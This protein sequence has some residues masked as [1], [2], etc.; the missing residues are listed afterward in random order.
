MKS[1]G[2]EFFEI[3]GCAPGDE[4]Y[5]DEDAEKQDLI[6]AIPLFTRS[7]EATGDK[8]RDEQKP[9]SNKELIKA[10]IRPIA[11]IQNRTAQE[12]FDI[13]ADRVRYALKAG[14]GQ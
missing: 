10:L 9:P 11:G 1:N 7:P 2:M 5:A 13:M 6:E 3:D 12:A 14:G 4:P 8:S